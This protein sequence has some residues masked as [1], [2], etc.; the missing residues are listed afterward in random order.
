MTRRF[1]EGDVFSAKDVA[2]LLQVDIESIYRF[3]RSGN[4]VG[5]KIGGS[6]WRI[7]ESDLDDFLIRARVVKE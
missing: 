1:I 3:V 6:Q 7:T 5:Y 2:E 4:L